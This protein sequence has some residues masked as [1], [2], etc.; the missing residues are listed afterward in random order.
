[1]ALFGWL[2]SLLVVAALLS[3]AP[4]VR[5]LLAMIAHTLTAIVCILI[6]RHLLPSLVPVSFPR[7]PAAAIRDPT[8]LL[9]ALRL[10]RT[11]AASNAVAADARHLAVSRA[12]RQGL[13][14]EKEELRAPLEVHLAPGEAAGRW[15]MKTGDSTSRGLPLWLTALA[16]YEGNREVAFYRHLQHLLRVDCPRA[17]LAAEAPLLARWC[18]VLTD[19]CEGDGPPRTYSRADAGGA[20]A[21]TDPAA[22]VGCIGTRQIQADERNG[23]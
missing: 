16:T 4:K 11:R 14:P 23:V 7:S 6:D 10:H 13:E 8:K 9:R 5:T 1:M 17:L 21:D 18:L 22:V 3:R 2:A 12:N 15:F 19:E 20:P